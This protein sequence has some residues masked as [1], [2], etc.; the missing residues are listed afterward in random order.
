MAKKQSTGGVTFELG[1]DE[2]DDLT[3]SQI[4]SV[5]ADA[6]NEKAEVVAKP[7]IRPS[8][9]DKLAKAAGYTD[10]HKFLRDEGYPAP[11]KLI[12]V[13]PAN[14]GKAEKFPAIEVEAF[15]ESDALRQFVAHY[16]SGREDVHKITL[17]A[18]VIEE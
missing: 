6:E 5:V 3:E 9:A 14:A 10:T 2:H 1:E 8:E 12:R 15:D 13:V 4:K 17:H 11:K 16:K 18:T 7:V